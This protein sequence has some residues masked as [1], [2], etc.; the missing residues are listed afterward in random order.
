MSRAYTEAGVDVAAGE[1][2]VALFRDRLSRTG[3]LAGEF[4]AL[5][6]IPERMRRPVVVTS[7]DGVGT[8][9]EIARRMGRLG[10]IGQDL[11]AM[12]ADDV[13]CHGAQ[14]A[15]FLDYIA[16]GKLNP[17]TVARLVEGVGEACESIGCALVGGETAEHPGL[18]PD[19]A[20]DLAGFCIGFVERDELIDASASRAGDLIV[21]MA[22][23]GL[24]SNGYSLIRRLVD[25]DRLALTDDLLAPTRLYAP[26]VLS[27]VA[28]L[29]A[30]GLRLG[31]LAHVTGGG[32]AR[33]LPRALGDDLAAVIHPGSWVVPE[34]FETV[35]RAALMTEEDMRATFNCGV[36]FAAVVEPAAADLAVELSGQHG[37]EAWVIGEVEPVASVGERY[38]EA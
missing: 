3:N 10:T 8:K 28:Q 35:R 38:V 21:G 37:I 15:Y 22:S 6:E 19:D 7:T 1:L 25:R 20:F 30:R 18:M 5:I 11:V 9:T 13:V 2:A 31:G 16:V 4:G 17:Q 34:I 12:C 32:L 26:A 14:P 23:N 33:N 27:V 24:H 29:K 36:G